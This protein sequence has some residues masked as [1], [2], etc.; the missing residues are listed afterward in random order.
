MK[1]GIVV[2]PTVAVEGKNF[3]FDC[4]LDAK[5]MRRHLLYWDEIAYA[6]ANEMGKPNF[7]HLLDLSYL[8]DVG[9]LSLQDIRITTDE[10]GKPGLPSP[11]EMKKAKALISFDKPTPDNPSGGILLGTPLSVWPELNHL[12][13]VKAASIL[14][15]K[16]AGTW[17]ISQSCNN[18]DLPFG[19][20]PNAKLFEANLYAC[21]PVPDEGTPLNEILE[22]KEKR[23]SQLIRFR[24]AIDDLYLKMLSSPDQQRELRKAS[25]EIDIALVELSRCLNESNMKTFFTSLSLYLN[26]QDSKFFTTLLGIYGATKAGFPLE[27]GAALGLG[28]NTAL[29]FATRCIEK[30]VSV[31]NELQDF[32]YLYE[33]REFWPGK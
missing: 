21:L 9:V 10:I 11:V 2:C 24:H 4:T 19:D 15:A 30:P 20:N 6:Y 18:L 31:P 1:H 5:E 28:V 26:I 8:R 16:G 7:E 17:T 3:N 25:E 33:A 22:F 12:A 32:M 14:Q 29:T 23:R 13:Q 27:I